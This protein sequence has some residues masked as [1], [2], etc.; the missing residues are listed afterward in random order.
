MGQIADVLQLQER[1]EDAYKQ[2]TKVLRIQ[3]IQFGA[4]HLEVGIT[5]AA[6]ARV[7]QKDGKLSESISH[8][9]KALAI[10]VGAYGMHDERVGEIMN[11]LALVHKKA[12]HLDDAYSLS[13]QVLAIVGPAHPTAAACLTNMA[14]ILEG[15]GKKAEA[16]EL[17]R[18][19]YRIFSATHG[20][21][22]AYSVLA[23]K[24]AKANAVE[25][26]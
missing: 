7:L 8:F 12:G 10:H 5:F 20:P 25:S 14:V 11:E 24:K 6:M 17:F 4:Q 13:E 26:C 15:K 3:V 19:A 18:K 2:H 1:W 16:A 9:D 22:H 23:D 21:A